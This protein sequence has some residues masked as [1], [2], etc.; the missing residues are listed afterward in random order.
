[1]NPP[2]ITTTA[3][4]PQDSPIATLA[5]GMSFSE[6]ENNYAL[7]PPSIVCGS[8]KGLNNLLL[9]EPFSSKRKIE[10]TNTCID[11]EPKASVS[12]IQLDRKDSNDAAN[13][14][15]DA[16][17]KSIKRNSVKKRS[18]MKGKERSSSANYEADML[19]NERL[20]SVGSMDAIEC[21]E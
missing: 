12:N 5:H 6:W 7:K 4:T 18:S 9:P 16:K 8:V 10:S 13:S 3:A 1:M 11:L 15:T 19:N 21:N 20:D 2:I 14:Q 17:S